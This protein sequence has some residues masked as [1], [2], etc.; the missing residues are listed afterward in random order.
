MITGI[1]HI[2]FAVSNLE[3]SLHFYVNLLGL[4]LV[5][6]WEKGAYLLAGEQWVALNYD[7][8]QGSKAA[9]HDSHIAFTV[10]TEYLEL[11]KAKLLE[12]GITAYRENRSEGNSFYFQDPDGHKLELHDSHLCQRRMTM[13][14]NQYWLSKP[15][16]TLQKTLT[17]Y[18]FEY[19]KSG[20]VLYQDLY[21]GI[22]ENF[23][24]YIL[25]LQDQE[26]GRQLPEGWANTTTLYLLNGEE[27]LG[28]VRIRHDLT[29]DYISNFIGHI[30]Y[31]VKPSARQKG[32]GSL[33]LRA[34]LDK[35]RQLGLQKV[36]VLCEKNNIASKAIIMKQ[37]GIFESEI[38]DDE[39]HCYLRFWINS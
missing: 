19:K 15:D 31:D 23:E 28:S 29:N 13:N 7:P 20:E 34:G 1:N 25:K 17:D 16:R 18:Y 6:R 37:G 10:T 3:V 38:I 8:K 26:K 36:L 11:L 14:L 5:E 9:A 30:G 27:V 24:A 35:A 39:G 32:V 4:E 22:V 12:H 21:Q 2:T 33:L